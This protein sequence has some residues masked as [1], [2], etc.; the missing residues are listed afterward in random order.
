MKTTITPKVTNIPLLFPYMPP[1]LWF[2]DIRLSDYLIINKPFG[3]IFYHSNPY[4]SSFRFENPF[5][6][7]L[8]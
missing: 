4:I 5:V 6:L 7:F 1:F 3:R 2:K 8:L